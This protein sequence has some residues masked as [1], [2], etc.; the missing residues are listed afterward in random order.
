MDW[1]ALG[2]V[3]DLISALG[4]IA[5][6]FYVAHQIRRNSTALEAAT[7]QAISDSAQNRLLA[8]AQSPDLAEAWAKAVSSQ[9]E[10][11]RRERAQVEF[12]VRATFRGIENAYVQHR[13]GLISQE[14][15]HG[16]EQ[17][18]RNFLRIPHLKRWWPGDRRQYEHTFA[19]YI[20]GIVSEE[21]GA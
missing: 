10:L 19:E 6:L 5:S 16:Q 17:L 12:F 7:N 3:A 20:D 8:L 1:E 14:S 18:L 21:P 15:W 2:A 13:Q 9:D 11:S 4:V